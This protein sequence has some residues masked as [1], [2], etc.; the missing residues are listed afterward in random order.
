[1]KRRAALPYDDGFRLLFGRSPL[2]K[3]IH[4]T[5]TRAFLEV[6][7]A[8]IAL[9]GYSREEF[10][11]MRVSDVASGEGPT[12]HRAKNGRLIDVEIS[13]QALQCDGRPAVLVVV[14]DA[15]ARKKADREIARRDARK[16]AA[17]EESLR[18]RTA[19]LHAA[20]EELDALTYSVSTDL[21]PPLRSIDGCIQALRDESGPPLSDYARHHLDRMGLATE[22]MSHVV[23][24]LLAL[25][26]VSRTEITRE[27]VDLSSLVAH[28]A[29][30][31][32]RRAPA[33]SVVFSVGSAVTAD[34]DPRLLRMLFEHLLDNAWKST[35]GQE[36]A[37]I[38][39]GATRHN[40][41]AW[42]YFVRD[43]GV[44]IDSAHAEGLFGPFLG[45][46]AA[47]ELR[48]PGIGLATVRRVVHRHGGRV[49]AEGQPGHGTS[50]FFTLA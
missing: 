20:I 1:M 23:D 19:E 10:L 26:K 14:H 2:P 28:I 31:L 7:D 8:A 30:D 4:D 45:L 44:G 27:R 40:G 42:I 37:Q 43:N 47:R 41:G 39:V 21:R 24:G 25:S 50:V 49:W 46:H 18:R 6:N 29:A 16:A 11:A 9:Y 12:R 36:H 34:G 32:R 33:R 35:D 17:L 38:E 15:S 22:H 3:W 13:L 48:G 5:E